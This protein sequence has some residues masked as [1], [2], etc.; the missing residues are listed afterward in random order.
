[1]S[2]AKRTRK[3]QASEKSSAP[4]K[5]RI[6]G[7][8]HRG[9]TIQ[10]S[11]DRRTRPMKDDVRE[12]VFNLVGGWVP[13]RA[14]F[15]LFAGTGAVGLEAISRG[16]S[17]AFFVERHFPTARI[18]RENV[19]QIAPDADVEIATSDTF[20]WA[21]QFL[22]DPQRWPDE[23]WV[24]FVCPPYDLFQERAADID[25]LIQN[26]FKVAPPDSLFVV[27]SDKRFDVRRLPQHEKWISRNYPP[28]VVNVFR[29]SKGANAFV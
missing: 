26:F 2:A 8:K 22:A 7:G 3:R 27:E 28:A 23:P 20:F 1:M 6:I 24:V 25:W 17:R 19:A 21:R 13:G 18:V 9:R 16:A 10:Y 14:V 4:V 5:L 29:E 15:D 12:A 11:G